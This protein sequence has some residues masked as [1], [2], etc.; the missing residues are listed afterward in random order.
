VL[1]D[2]H[3]I[4]DIIAE[5]DPAERLARYA[6]MVTAIDRRI[7]ALWRALEGAQ[8]ATPMRAGSLPR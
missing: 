1:R 6:V 5:P 4:A 2:R 3:E 8:P 7:S